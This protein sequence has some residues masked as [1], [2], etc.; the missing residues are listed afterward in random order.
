MRYRQDRR[1]IYRSS[2]F[3]D[4]IPDHIGTAAVRQV[5]F[6]IGAVFIRQ[7]IVQNVIRRSSGFYQLP[8][9]KW[10]E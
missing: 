9:M 2:T 4:Q 5:D 7:A 10:C 3:F 6:V 1:W 8:R